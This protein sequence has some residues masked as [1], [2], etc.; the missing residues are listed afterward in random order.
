MVVLTVYVAV[1][2]GMTTAPLDAEPHA[3]GD[4]ELTAQFELVANPDAC[5]L[6]VVFWLGGVDASPTRALSWSIPVMPPSR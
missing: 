2:V 5:T 1:V 4:T 6:P 3:A